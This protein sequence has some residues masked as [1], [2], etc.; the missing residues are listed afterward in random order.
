[1]SG[2]RLEGKVACIS[3]TGGGQGRAA[4]QLFAAEGAKVVG[5]DVKAEGAKETVELVSAAGGEMIS[6][7][8]LDVSTPAGASEWIQAGLDA[9]G[10]VDILYNNASGVRLV[11]IDDPEAWDAWR[12]G[13]RHEADIVFA[14]VRA[15]W[16][17]LRASR[18]TIVNTSSA[19]ALRGLPIEGL[20]PGSSVGHSAAKAAV[21]GLT[22]QVAAE[23]APHGI[24]ANSLIPGFVE[25]PGTASVL[26]DDE[27]RTRI[28]ASIPLGRIGRPDDLAKAALFLASDESSWITAETLVVDGGW[29]RIG[30]SILD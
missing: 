23:G 13:M 22:Q 14:G 6:V 10:R 7:H 26:D 25:V 11:A 18:G 24:R 8:P 20:E 9:Y 30:M 29:T 5:C 19:A 1:M 27:I 2:G 16:E 4:A 28:A 17:A 15:A 12:E 3:G 21:I